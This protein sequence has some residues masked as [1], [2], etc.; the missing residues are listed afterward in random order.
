[1]EGSRKG[2]TIGTSPDKKT[3]GLK[4]EKKGRN[5]GKSCCRGNKGGTSGELARKEGGIKSVFA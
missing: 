3:G 4:G 5:G 1:L 2:K